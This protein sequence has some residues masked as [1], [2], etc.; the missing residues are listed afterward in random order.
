L[1]RAANHRAI[2]FNFPPLELIT[3]NFTIIAI[4]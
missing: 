1:M 3:I 2:S 4:L